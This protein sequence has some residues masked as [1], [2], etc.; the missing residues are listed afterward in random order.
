MVAGQVRG[1]GRQKEKD[2]P[3]WVRLSGS[4]L[5]AHMV[6]AVTRSFWLDDLE[7]KTRCHQRVPGALRLGILG[8]G[9]ADLASSAPALLVAYQSRESCP[10]AA[11]SAGCESRVSRPGRGP[12]FHAGVA[13]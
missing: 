6:S 11:A 10:S 1:R 5:N 13:G 12:D 3:N 4:H 8:R 2:E 7:S 9:R